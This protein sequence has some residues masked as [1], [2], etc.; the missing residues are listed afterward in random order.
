MSCSR[1]SAVSAT[2]GTGWDSGCSSPA[3]SPAHTVVSWRSSMVLVR[4]SCSPCRCRH[5]FSKTSTLGLTELQIGRRC[6]VQ[7]ESFVQPTERRGCPPVPVA[8]QRHRCR[9]EQAAH[10][11]GVNS[12]RDREGEPHLLDAEVLAQREAQE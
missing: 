6:L 12:Y 3:R 10:D 1:S 8:E 7:T 9:D 2:P 4:R 5:R 11:R